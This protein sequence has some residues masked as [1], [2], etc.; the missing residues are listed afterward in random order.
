MNVVYVCRLHARARQSAAVRP[1]SRSLVPSAQAQ[2]GQGSAAPRFLNIPFHKLEARLILSSVAKVPV[3]SGER[4]GIPAFATP[5]PSASISGSLAKILHAK[6]E[7]APES[8]DKS[9][10]FR[11]NLE[12]P[13][14][15]KFEV[16]Y[17]LRILLK[18]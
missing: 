14:I 11:P 17:C 12:E 3:R 16:A 2:A 9:R 18:I 5:E 6:I 8:A 10:A 1:T 4:L 7:D 15:P 13:K